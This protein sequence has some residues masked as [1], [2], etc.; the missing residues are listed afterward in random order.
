ML[1]PAQLQASPEG[2]ADYLAPTF[3]LDSDHAAVIAFAKRAAG[4]TPDPVEQARR[5]YYAVRDGLRY[6]P[7]SFSWRAE[8]Y[9]ASDVLRRGLGFCVPKTILLAAAARVLGIPSRLGFADVRNHLNTARLRELMETDVFAYHG[10]VEMFVEGKW[11]KSTPAFNIELCQ[12]FRVLP[13]EFDGRNDSLMHPYDAD[14]RRHMEYLLDR[15]VFADMPFEMFCKDMLLIYPRLSEVCRRGGLGGDF[16][17]ET[18]SEHPAT[19]DAPLIAA[20]A[21]QP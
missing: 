16:A 10:Y 7:Y 8:A 19:T 3:F 12:K 15:G 6:D 4:E 18:A 13:L 5:L 1:Q 11:V 20:K 21:A 9:R 17:A 2:F 14:N